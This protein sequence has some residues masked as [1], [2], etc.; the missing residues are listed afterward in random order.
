M[1]LKVGGG[2]AQIP[3]TGGRFHG[4]PVSGNQPYKQPPTSS[5]ALEEYFK[6][7]FVLCF[8]FFFQLDDI[9][10]EQNFVSSLLSSLE[11]WVE[12]IERL[13]PKNKE[14]K[15]CNLPVDCLQFFKVWMKTIHGIM[16][17]VFLL[18]LS[19]G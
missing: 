19:I 2:P 7:C 6:H 1:P 11:T 17:K 3:G 18:Y 5:V 15:V 13:I 9:Y 16:C 12:L 4:N 14:R 10:L 8:S